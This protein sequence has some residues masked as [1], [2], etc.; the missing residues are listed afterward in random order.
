MNVDTV[1]GSDD[2]SPEADKD[3][4]MKQCPN[5]DQSFLKKRDWQVFC[6][7]DCRMKSHQLEREAA[8][9]EYRMMKRSRG[10][11]DAK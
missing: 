5:C 11:G 2:G 4:G 10:V 1:E 6:S 3:Y 7:T 8:V 9:R